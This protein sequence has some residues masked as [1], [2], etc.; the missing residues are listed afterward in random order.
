MIPRMDQCP[1]SLTPAQHLAR[2]E[3]AQRDLREFLTEANR[4]Q[5]GREGSVVGQPKA[6]RGR[7]MAPLGLVMATL[8]GFAA[9][10]GVGVAV[11]RSWGGP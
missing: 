4:Q 8:G 3:Q 11:V 9:F 5:A 1:E 2:I 6:P 10:F 7:R